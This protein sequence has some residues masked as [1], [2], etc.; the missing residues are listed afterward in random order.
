MPALRK[1]LSS[2]KERVLKISAAI[3]GG[4]LFTVCLHLMLTSIKP[5]R[6]YVAILSSVTFFIVWVTVML[7]VFLSK[8]GWKAWGVLLLSSIL[9]T[10]IYFL[11]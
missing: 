5:I 9:L 11:L 3:L 10:G 2:G 8:S 6:D 7:L 1:Y 4:Y